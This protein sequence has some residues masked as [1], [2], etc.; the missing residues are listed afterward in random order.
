MGDQHMH[1]TY[2]YDAIASVREQSSVSR[3]IE[4]GVRKQ[5]LLNCCLSW[6][7][8]EIM[9]HSLSKVRVSTEGT[10]FVSID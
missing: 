6:K 4:W 3:N 7:N 2:L 1:D 5:V 9:L 10:L 8:Q